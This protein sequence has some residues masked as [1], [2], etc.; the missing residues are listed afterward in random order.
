MNSL[1]VTSDL[2]K[3]YPL[4]EHKVH[5]LRG[6]EMSVEPGQFVLLL[7]PS[8]S[9]KSSLLHILGA[10]DHPSRGQVSLLGQAVGGLSPRQQTALRLRSIG[11]V[12][13]S[14]NLMPALA[15]YADRVLTMVDGRLSESA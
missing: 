5:A 3:T 4:G 10:M 6:V 13:Q 11:F 1:I 8:G 9:G 12:F 2:W 15:G 14:F 7:G